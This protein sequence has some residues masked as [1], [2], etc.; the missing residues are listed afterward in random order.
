MNL[1]SGEL[2]E[3]GNQ[4][5]EL[6]KPEEALACY[7]WAFV[8]A[9]E[10]AAAF[11]NYGNVLREVGY[12]ARSIPFL[13]HAI[14]LDPSNVTFKMNL[15]IS[16]LL[17]GNYKEGWAG[18]EARWNYEHLAGSL[19][20][21]SEPRW[22]GQ[23]LKDK[24]LLVVGEQ[25]H[26][27]IIQ[28][29]RFLFHLRSLGCKIILQVTDGLRPLLKPGNI[30]SKTIGYLDKPEGFDYWVPIMS[31]ARVIGVTLENLP[32]NLS[33][34]SADAIPVQEW[35]IRL[36]TR[37]KLR[38]GF[39]WSGRRDAW[40]NRHKGM[41]FADMLALI[42]K[43]PE[44]QWVSLQVD[45]T[46]EETQALIDA[47]VAS[48]PGTIQSFADTAALITNLD[49]VLS[50]DTAIA[51]LSGALGRPTW[52]MLSQFAVDWRWLLDRDSS[53]W[54]PS[55]K[56]FRQPTRGDWTSVTD[57]ISRFLKLFKI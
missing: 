56:L 1:N 30:I 52:I 43:N 17:L 15:A 21:H 19:P 41:P 18:Y 45:A 53:P 55:A 34:L 48:Y 6:T 39:S 24:T 35:N 50:V 51:H 47:G 28:H 27:D 37:T 57:K 3:Q 20:Q 49:V 4:L 23:D 8:S 2:I 54:Y 26:G 5:R 46:A 7:A 25:G 9:P 29:S 12:P 14:V 33:Y 38:V 32:Q 42:K 31:I 13:Q 44:Y 22:E 40:L 36:G 16:H 10:S 11:N